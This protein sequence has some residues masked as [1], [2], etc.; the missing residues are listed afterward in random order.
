M[1]NAFELY[2]YLLNNNID[3]IIDDRKDITLGNRINDV[4]LLGT[5]KVLILGNRFDGTNYEIENLKDNSK[6]NVLKEE[7]IK[8]ILK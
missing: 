5:P 3:V 8:E 1:N 2:N 4:L 7:I 6:T